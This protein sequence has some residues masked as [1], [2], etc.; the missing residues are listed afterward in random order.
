VDDQLVAVPRHC[1]GVRLDGVVVVARRRVDDVDFD[2]A[3]ASAASASPISSFSGWPMNRPGSVP[4]AL[5]S[6]S[7]IAGSAS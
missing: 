7:V 5:A 3:P 6:K 1:R 4:L 2:G